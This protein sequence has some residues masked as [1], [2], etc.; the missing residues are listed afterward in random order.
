MYIHIDRFVSEIIY[1][2]LSFTFL[3]ATIREWRKKCKIFRRSSNLGPSPEAM[4]NDRSSVSQRQTDRLTDRP[5][6]VSL[7]KRKAYRD[8]TRA[9]REV[10]ALS[11]RSLPYHKSVQVI[12]AR[13]IAWLRALTRRSKRCDARAPRTHACRVQIWN[14]Y[15]L[16]DTYAYI[17]IIV[18]YSYDIITNYYLYKFYVAI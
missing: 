2:G 10:F 7:P 15:I 9:C 3:N 17:S 16:I 18:H 13:A 8:K 6:I 1:L 4:E 12:V 11:D 5:N 14:W